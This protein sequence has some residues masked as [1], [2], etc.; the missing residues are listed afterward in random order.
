MESD[1][2]ETSAII[3]REGTDGRQAVGESYGSE[4][5][6]EHEHVVAD[7]R[8]A[9]GNDDRDGTGA[10]RDDVKVDLLT[11]RVE[12][13]TAWVGAKQDR[14]IENRRFDLLRLLFIPFKTFDKMLSL[15]EN[16]ATSYI[17]EV[18]NEMK[19]ELHKERIDALTR[20]K[21][22]PIDECKNCKSDI[23]FI[24]SIPSR[25]MIP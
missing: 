19:A 23:E 25:I 22:M 8:H 2:G 24:Q 17:R 12:L 20:K 10:G 7:G 5:G 21:K 1:R 9:V 6:A 3:E 4:D 16:I 11:A 15:F 13:L 14:E 18:R